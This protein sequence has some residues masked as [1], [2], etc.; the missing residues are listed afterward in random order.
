MLSSDRYL[1]VYLWRSVIQSR[2]EAQPVFRLYWNYDTRSPY[3]GE[4]AF[5]EVSIAQVQHL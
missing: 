3:V 5:S 4:G 1:E 2:A